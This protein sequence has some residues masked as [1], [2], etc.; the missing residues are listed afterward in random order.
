[1]IIKCPHCATNNT[2]AYAEHIACGECKKNF[3]GESFTKLK[4]PLISAGVTLILG[5]YAGHKVESWM[6]ENRYPLSIEY[7]IVDTCVNNSSRSRSITYYKDLRDV[8][9]CAAETSISE[10]P[11]RDFKESQRLLSEPF[12]VAFSAC[13]KGP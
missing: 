12:N 7:A 11:Y 10:V 5:V 6:D 8:C 9:L 2:I 1:M 3:Q 13:N 4:K